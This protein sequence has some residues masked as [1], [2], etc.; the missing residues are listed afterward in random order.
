[1]ILSLLRYF[2]GNVDFYAEGL[3]TES[4]YTYC[5]K[6][7]VEILH[8]Q[9]IGY[10]LYAEIDSKN[11]KKLRAPAKKYGLKLRLLKK[12]G[13]YFFAKKNKNK[14]GIAAGAIFIV[15]FSIFMNLF[16][17]EINVIGNDKTKTDEIIKSA[18]EMGLFTGTLA[19][20]HSVQN[21][22]W[23]ILRENSGLAS[24]QIN[25][26]GSVANILIN[27]REEEPKMV[28][29]DDVP[30]NLVASKYG[31]VR[32]MNVYD[33]QSTVKTGDAVMKGDLLVSA[34]YEDSHNKLTL[35][36][37]RADVFAETDYNISVEYPLEEKIQ[38]IDKI[39]K[40]IYEINFLGFSF[41]FGN[42]KGL[43]GLPNDSSEKN[44]SFLGIK[45]PITVTKTR[46]FDVKYNTI[47][48]SFEQGRAGAY[49]LLNKKENELMNEMEILSRKTEEKVKEGVYFINADYIVLMNIAQEQ[50]IE[51]DIPWKN[52]DDMS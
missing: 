26:Q 7:S 11:Y 52:T 31:V 28:S 10:R 47:T 19:R 35:K 41:N 3:D 2:K 12:H 51:S 9:K 30:T 16:I 6:K 36:H 25:I 27:E 15:C 43:E 32:K 22:E 48:Y 40:Q 46:Y 23:Y 45:L 38:K 29:D 17:W 33:G 4:F 20:S 14:I 21:M 1:M 8:P 39:K 37:A 44:L 18:E 50:P 34:V 42:S 5:S 13:I 49:D 24:V